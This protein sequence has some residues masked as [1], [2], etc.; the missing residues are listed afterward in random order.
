MDADGCGDCFDWDEE[1]LNPMTEPTM[2][3]KQPEQAISQPKPSLLSVS[4]QTSFE[5]VKRPLAL[6]INGSWKTIQISMREEFMVERFLGG[7]VFSVSAAAFKLRFRK[8]V[9]R[10]VFARWLTRPWVKAYVNLRMKSRGMY[11]RY[12]GPGGKELWM[13]ELME[14]RGGVEGSSMKGERNY[15]NK[16]HMHEMIG[17]FM[18]FK[19]ESKQGPRSVMNMQINFTEANGKD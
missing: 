17:E 5:P 14:M 13:S 6:E 16:I 7:E 4:S 2:P 12:A 1:D 3:E 10:K 8:D 18:G 9:S 11:N 15:F 19:T